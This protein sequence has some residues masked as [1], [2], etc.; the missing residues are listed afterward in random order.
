MTKVSRKV[1]SMRTL[2]M[3]RVMVILIIWLFRRGRVLEMT[4]E[5]FK[6]EFEAFEVFY[7]GT[8]FLEDIKS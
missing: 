2:V 8:L 7:V 5:V 6:G 3:G 4:H 1:G